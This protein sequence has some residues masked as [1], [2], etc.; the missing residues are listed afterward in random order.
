[1]GTWGRSGVFRVMGNVCVLAG[2]VAG[3]ACYSGIDGDQGGSADSGADGANDD[4]DEP[5][6]ENLEPGPASLRLLLPQQYVESIRGLLGD[7]AA[8][9]AS[10]PAAPAALN[11]FEAIGA[12]QLALGDSAI[13]AF[14]TSAQRVAEVAVQDE[15][16]M[17]ALRGCTPAG[18]DDAACHEAFVARFGRLAFRRPLSDVELEQYTAVAMTAAAEL[19]VFEEGTRAAIATLLQSPNFL[20]QVEIGEAD[21]NDAGLRRLSGYEVA[22]RVAF[23]L[24]GATPDEDL[25]DDA[26]AGR[27][28]GADGVREAARKLLETDG[29]RV[30]LSSFMSEL[31]RLRDLDSLPKDLGT[32][33]AYSPELA[34][35]MRAETLALIE[36]IA[37]DEDGDFRDILDADYTF[38][39]A[40]LAAHYGMDAEALPMGMTRATPPPEHK[41][42]GI[43]GHAGM[44]SLLSHVSSS[45]PSVRGKFVRETIM[46]ENIPAPPPEVATD[47]PSSEDQTTRERLEEHMNIG[48]CAGC[49]SLMDPIGFGLEIYD[50]IGAYRTT[51]NGLA[52]DAVSEFA[53]TPFEGAKELGAILK[54]S[55]TVP[56]C[57][58]RNLYRHG[59]GHL[60]TLGELEQLQL[61]TEVFAESGYSLQDVLVEMVANPAFR[62]VGEPQ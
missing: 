19:G 46:C 28:D 53:G 45:S 5:A 60:E 18:P 52:I 15:A 1:M 27:L 36:H 51:E 48:T 56:L 13:G 54:A 11:G 35:S 44:L 6:P 61:V 31:L 30:A 50:G 39:D 26:E 25:L 59:S 21:P 24:T 62:I 33:P 57:L 23:F 40:S 47:L 43:L 8:D 49:H 37:W 17:Q 34:A 2:L 14:E 16:R 58:V 32:Y 12:A 22:T 3:S 41:R 9:V 42:G 20:Y 7:A 4:G 10:P 38:V 29:A 55:P